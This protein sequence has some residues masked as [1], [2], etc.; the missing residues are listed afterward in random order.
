V[1]RYFRDYRSDTR[2]LYTSAA[3]LE[4]HRGPGYTMGDVRGQPERR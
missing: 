2:K 1:E 3:R 4:D